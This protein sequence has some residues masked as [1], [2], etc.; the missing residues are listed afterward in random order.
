MHIINGNGTLEFEEWCDENPE[1]WKYGNLR[2]RKQID[3]LFYF[4]RKEIMEFI[5]DSY[6]VGV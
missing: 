6:L 2:S 3:F 5:P 4:L 1:H